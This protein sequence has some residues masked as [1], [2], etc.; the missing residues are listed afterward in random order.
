M[1]WVSEQMTVKYRIIRVTFILLLA[2]ANM[3]EICVIISG[4]GRGCFSGTYSYYIDYCNVVDSSVN[5]MA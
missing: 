4:G 1:G 5:F 3:F 2:F